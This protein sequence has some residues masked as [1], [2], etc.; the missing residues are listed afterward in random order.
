M[1]HGSEFISCT[2]CH[3]VTSE[4]LKTV[5]TTLKYTTHV[6]I[7]TLHAKLIAA[8]CIVIG[9]VCGLVFVLLY[10]GCYITICIVFSYAQ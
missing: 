3:V 8:Q 7:F 1:S 5:K 2:A 9:A 4:F 6:P 10:T